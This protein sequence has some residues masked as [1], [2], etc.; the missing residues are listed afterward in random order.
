LQGFGDIFGLAY[1]KDGSVYPHSE[2][3]NKYSMAHYYTMGAHTCAVFPAGII[4]LEQANTKYFSIAKKITLNHPDY[5]NAITPSAIVAARLG[6]VDKTVERLGDMVAYLQHF[7]QGLFYNIDHWCNLSRYVNKVDSAKLIT[8]RDYIFDTRATYNSNTG[9]SGLW[10]QPFIQCGMETLGVYGTAVNEMLMQCQEN[11][12]RVFP[13]TPSNWESAF[14]LL[15][16]G[17]FL[18]SS[19][20]DKNNVIH[21]VEIMSQHG[22]TCKIQNPWPHKS[23]YIISGK[24]KIAYKIDKNDVIT[25]NTSKGKRY[26]I[27]DSEGNKNVPII[28]TSKMNDKP[29]HFSEATLGKERTFDTLY[30]K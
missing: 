27:S 25:F 21:G 26:L 24:K 29:K 10:A 20:K 8:Q 9:N 11:K 15:A 22:N 28:F 16:G 19:Y 30:K 13:A 18:V 14:T 6:L 2:D 4:G 23:V 3:Y 7:N 12:I 5:I 1:Y 17:A